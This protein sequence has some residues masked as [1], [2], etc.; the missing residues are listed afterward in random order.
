MMMMS[1]H[2]PLTKKQTRAYVDQSVKVNPQMVK[3]A[4][5]STAELIAI[6]S[7]TKETTHS[8]YSKSPTL[9]LLHLF[10]RHLLFL[11][12]IFGRRQFLKKA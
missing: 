5:E 12:I 4:E 8:L 7:G 9:M 3:G 6:M 1:K 10:H 11:R 2:K